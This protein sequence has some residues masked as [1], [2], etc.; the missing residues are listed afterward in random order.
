MNETELLVRNCT[1][2]IQRFSITPCL[3]GNIL[4]E[5]YGLWWDGKFKFN[6]HTRIIQDRLNKL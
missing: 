6:Q 2:F 3:C 4:I 5:I 1:E